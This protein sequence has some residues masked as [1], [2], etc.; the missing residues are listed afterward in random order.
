M[1]YGMAADPPEA[2]RDQQDGET[3]EDRRLGSGESE[4]GRAYCLAANQVPGKTAKL[5]AQACSVQ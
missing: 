3:G 2:E 5:V 4:P 1:P